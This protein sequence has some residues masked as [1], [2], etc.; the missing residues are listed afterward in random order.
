MN[1]DTE[2]LLI[3]CCQRA[4]VSELGGRKYKILNADR[5][6]EVLCRF[7]RLCIFV[8]VFVEW[9]FVVV[10]RRGVRRG[11]IRS[12]V[13]VVSCVLCGSECLRVTRPMCIPGC[14]YRYAKS[15]SSVVSTTGALLSGPAKLK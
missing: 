4:Y 6:D 8:I 2:G 9:V 12:V 11:C 14:L 15:S 3:F 13:F 1:I 7:T 10:I 5:V